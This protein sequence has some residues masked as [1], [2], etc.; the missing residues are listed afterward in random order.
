[1]LLCLYWLDKF[2]LVD[3][4]GELFSSS[5]VLPRWLRVMCQRTISRLGNKVPLEYLHFPY[6][7]GPARFILLP[8]GLQ[9]LF[10]PDGDFGGNQYVSLAL[11]ITCLIQRMAYPGGRGPQDAVLVSSHHW[12]SRTLRGTNYTLV[13][14]VLIQRLGT[15]GVVSVGTRC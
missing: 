3:N 9:Q 10:R 14:S 7:M 13:S 1:M 15:S 12:L 6:A 5:R 11:A 8:Q 4:Y 2:V